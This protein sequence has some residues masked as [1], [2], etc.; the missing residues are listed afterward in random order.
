MKEKGLVNVN[1]FLDGDRRF[2]LSFPPVP[3]HSV[4]GQ[5]SADVTLS[6]RDRDIFVKGVVKF[7]HRLQCARCLREILRPR[8]EKIQILYTPSRLLDTELE[9]T[10]A[11][12]N[13][14]FYEGDLID[15]EQPIR[16]AI[17]LSM[18]MKLLC[19][20]DC[21]G[22]CPRCGKN[23]NEE[24]CGCEGEVVDPRWKA[25]EKLLR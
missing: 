16:D 20:P 24:E 14:L 5:V 21:K 6:R 19:K 10:E 17:V 23:L 2:C 13:T 9:L 15:L 8:E 22:L 11:D 12:V 3:G 1:Q 25:L 7:T 18:P 4:E